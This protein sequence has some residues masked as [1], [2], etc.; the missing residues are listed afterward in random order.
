MKL[1]K[2][3][4]RSLREMLEQCDANDCVVLSHP[5]IGDPR[6][7]ELSAN[8]CQSIPSVVI[9]HGFDP[10]VARLLAEQ[11]SDLYR[12]MD[13]VDSLANGSEVTISPENH[14]LTDTESE[15]VFQLLPI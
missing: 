5:L 3:N 6:Q 10:Y 13:P 7:I 2:L 14:A 11:G 8:Q 12:A 1:R 4:T 9:C 15:R